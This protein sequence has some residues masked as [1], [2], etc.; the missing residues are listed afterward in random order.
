MKKKLFILF[1][2]I[3]SFLISSFFIKNI[4]IANTPKINPFFA[5]NISKKIT[6]GYLSLKNKFGNRSINNIASNDKITPGT[7]NNFQATFD[8]GKSLSIPLN[9]ISTGIYAGERDDIKVFKV[10]TDEV[11]WLE[12][13]FVVD[14][15]EIKINVP[16]GELAP[17][18]ETVEEIY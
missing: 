6:L 9:K 11:D 5:S 13:T 7:S 14:G 18:Q 1:T 16:K 2:I 8:I 3:L 15:K 17:S 12:Y 10:K 4:F